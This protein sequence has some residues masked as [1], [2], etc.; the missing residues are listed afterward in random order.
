M[1][2]VAKK[3]EKGMHTVNSQRK[4]IATRL[5]AN[6]FYKQEIFGNANYTRCY[7]SNRQLWKNN[8]GGQTNPLP[9]VLYTNPS[10]ETLHNQYKAIVQMKY[11]QNHN[12][13]LYKRQPNSNLHYPEI[14][15]AKLRG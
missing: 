15:C 9:L 8:D 10:N 6:R 4:Y 14:R 7:W 2:K 1:K 13:S 11:A 3:S 12:I 5:L